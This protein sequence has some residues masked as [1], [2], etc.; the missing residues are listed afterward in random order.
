M[1]MIELM[2]KILGQ[3]IDHEHKQVGRCVYCKICKH[4][5]YQGTIMTASE[6][7]ALKEAIASLQA[8][9]TP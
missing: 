4:R 5:L 8:G 3:C 1:N 6:R 7:A 2:G 9:G